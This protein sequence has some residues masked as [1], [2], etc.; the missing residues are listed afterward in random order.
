MKRLIILWT[1]IALLVAACN[2]MKVYVRKDEAADFSKYK[3][4][5]F[6]QRP[7]DERVYGS[8]LAE[9][10]MIYGIQE[11]L[12]ARGLKADTTA[13]DLLVS[14]KSN[15]QVS[16]KQVTSV[17]PMWGMPMWG[18]YDP[19]FWGPAMMNPWNQ[20]QTQTITEA[21]GTIELFLFER[22]TKKPVWQGAA[23]GNADNPYENVRLSLQKLFS[24]FPLKRQRPYPKY[25]L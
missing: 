13:P 9:N 12:E 5:A 2:P 10:E 23:I 1:I 22:I 24:R 8:L 25:D 21:K 4:F 17:P 3:T 18:F 15:A 11:E 19:F 6:L 20:R 7:P 16:Q 14:F